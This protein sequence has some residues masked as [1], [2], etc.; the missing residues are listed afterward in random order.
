MALNACNPELLSTAMGSFLPLSQ[1]SSVFS[2][3]GKKKR[4]PGWFRYT[5]Y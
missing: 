3:W 2:Q 5:L 1:Q 4:P